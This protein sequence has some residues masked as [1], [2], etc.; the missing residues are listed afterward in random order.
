MGHRRKA[1]LADDA[2]RLVA[3]LPW[4]VGVVLAVVLYALL[5]WMSITP[6]KPPAVLPGQPFPISYVLMGGIAHGLAHAGQYALPLLCLVG[7]GVSLWKRREGKQL[8]LRATQVEGQAAVDGMTWRE[9]E[10]LVA[11]GYRLRG[12]DAKHVGNDGPD[13]GID[14]LLKKG[15]ERFL[16]QC[17]HW[18][19]QRVG[20][21]VVRQLYG[22]MAAKGATGGFV[23]TSGAFSNDAREFAEGRN[24]ELVDGPALDKL[25]RE[26]GGV[27]PV[28]KAED[29]EPAALAPPPT[30]PRCDQPMVRRSAR[31]G[32]TPG[33][34]FW[35]CGGFPKCR[36]SRSA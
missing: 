26:A 28:Q 3:M 12:Y 30:C 8:I 2:I 20:V 7:A 22:V 14:V 33:G 32:A 1:S 21:D 19:A 24:I 4:W 23:V 15:R 35:G 10:R 17:K 31:R 16:V 11:E 9:F 6:V 36:G 29:Q 13:G 27:H 25:L 18:R 5:H 34:E